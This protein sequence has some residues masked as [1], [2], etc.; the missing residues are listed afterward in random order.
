[1]FLSSFPE[2]FPNSNF[3]FH[4]KWK[5]KFN[6]QNLCRNKLNINIRIKNDDFLKTVQKW[7]KNKWA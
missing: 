3:K 4:L 5:N 1:M 7:H 6:H 2:K